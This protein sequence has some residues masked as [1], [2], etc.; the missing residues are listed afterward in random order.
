MGIW[1]AFTITTVGEAVTLGRIKESTDKE[2]KRERGRE[3]WS[4]APYACPAWPPLTLSRPNQTNKTG[5]T[6]EMIQGRVSADPVVVPHATWDN[7]WQWFY[8]RWRTR[9]KCP[10]LAFTDIDSSWYSVTDR[11]RLLCTGTRWPEILSKTLN[12][13]SP[14]GASWWWLQLAAVKTLHNDNIF[15][16]CDN[17]FARAPMKHVHFLHCSIQYAMLNHTRFITAAQQT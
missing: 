2:I 14:N 17:L 5:A 11:L 1:N 16:P 12:F 10:F 7:N 9:H 15:S 4:R 8:L 13:L 6:T 3:C